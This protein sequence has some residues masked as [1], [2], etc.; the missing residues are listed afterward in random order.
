[1][2]YHANVTAALHFVR[3]ILPLIRSSWP[4][5][6]LRI[7]GS[8]PPSSIQVLAQDPAIT[9]TGHVDDI[10]EALGRA[11]IAV[12]PVTVKVGI[13]NK[14]LEAMSMALPVVCSVAG[15]AGLSAQPGRDFLVAD[16]TAAF[17][18]EVSRLLGDA[19]LRASLG[20]AGRHYVETHHRWGAAA[21]QLERLYREAI[22]EH[23]ARSTAVA[24]SQVGRQIP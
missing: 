19:G 8:N 2:S 7:V 21:E 5:V 14:V 16:G 6:R 13:Q 3:N 17:A 24:R 18:A 23:A 1:M 4:D 22:D 10:R 9:V 15:A 12:C 11:T 20:Q